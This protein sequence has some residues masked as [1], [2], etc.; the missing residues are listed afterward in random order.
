MKAVDAVSCKIEDQ[1]YVRV[2][3]TTPYFQGWVL[4]Y[5]VEG[6]PEPTES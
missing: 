5:E 6:I 2:A 1:F 3:G 4:G